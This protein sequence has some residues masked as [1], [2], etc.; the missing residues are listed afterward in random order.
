MCGIAGIISFN[1]SSVSEETL[2]EM[3]DTLSHRGIADAGFFFGRYTIRICPGVKNYE[4]NKRAHIFV[5]LN[6]W[7]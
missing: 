3:R 5:S 1:N 4:F 7:I 6:W 2:L